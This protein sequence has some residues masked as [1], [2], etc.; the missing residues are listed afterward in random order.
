MLIYDPAI[1][2]GFSCHVRSQN[3]GITA[4]V[5]MKYRA[6]LRYSKSVM[7]IWRMQVNRAIS[8]FG[9]MADTRL[10][11]YKCLVE[12]EMNALDALRFC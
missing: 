3:I 4:S 6:L 1:S 10:L 9:F 2:D 12:R 5:K 8:Y 11:V 7:R